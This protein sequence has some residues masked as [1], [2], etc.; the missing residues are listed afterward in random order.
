MQKTEIFNIEPYYTVVIDGSEVS[1]FSNS[2]NAKGRALSIW[3]D[4]DG[5]PCVKVNNKSVKIHQLIAK[6]YLGERLD[7]FCVNHKD[8]VKTNNHPSNLEYLTISENTLH[9]IENG[10]HIC[11]TPEKLNT[12]KDGRTRD[13]RKYQREWNKNKRLRIKES[14]LEVTNG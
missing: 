1:V 8:G 14:K 5:Y 2:K 6:Y 11:T 3:I 13:R 12:Y 10:L 7:G 4:R 9:S